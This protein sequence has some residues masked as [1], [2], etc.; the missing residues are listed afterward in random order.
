M[1][2]YLRTMDNIRFG[3]NIDVTQGSNNIPNGCCMIDI[4]NSIDIEQKTRDLASS[5][6]IYITGNCG[7]GW[8]QILPSRMCDGITLRYPAR[9]R[10]NWETAFQ[11]Q[12][13]LTIP[14]ML[15]TN[16]KLEICATSYSHFSTD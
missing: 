7:V 9:T 3:E 12:E 10:Q 2:I 11:Q 14:G 1:I 8:I 15:H 6:I 16:C 4:H 5:F 13:R